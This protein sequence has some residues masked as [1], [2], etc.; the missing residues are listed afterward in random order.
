LRLFRGGIAG[1]DACFIKA[2]ATNAETGDR[3]KGLCNLAAIANLCGLAVQHGGAGVAG[4]APSSAQNDYA[5]RCFS[6]W[7]FQ[8][9]NNIVVSSKG[10]V[11]VKAKANPATRVLKRMG[12]L[13]KK[14]SE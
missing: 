4:T 9:Y 8:F 14:V 3:A 7:V 1:L 11:A 13:L 6:N 12:R 5:V 2:R 10:W